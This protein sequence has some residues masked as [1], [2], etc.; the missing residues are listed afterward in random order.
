MAHFYLRLITQ[1]VG[2]IKTAMKQGAG[3][4]LQFMCLG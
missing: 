3:S 4:H 1:S 2:T